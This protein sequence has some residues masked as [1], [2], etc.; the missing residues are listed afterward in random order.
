MLL[1]FD[2]RRL[3][4]FGSLGL[5]LLL[6]IAFYHAPDYVPAEVSRMKTSVSTWLKGTEPSLDDETYKDSPHFNVPTT[7]PADEEAH[8][9]HAVQPS[10]DYSETFSQNDKP[11]LQ[12]IGD[13]KVD[14][15]P[16][17]RASATRA[18]L[19][20]AATKQLP[21]VND[22]VAVLPPIDVIS[23]SADSVQATHSVTPTELPAQHTWS[24]P[25]APVTD[26]TYSL[27]EPTKRHTV[28]ET[29][30]A[31]HTRSTVSSPTEA[32]GQA[33]DEDKWAR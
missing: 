31:T 11:A 12:V 9:E 2:R 29:T 22:F 15:L 24:L 17:D 1:N 4:I 32:V 21:D 30:L 13:D 10:I 28:L 18:A 20:S 27:P 7:P 3:Y 14:V 26:H 8:V 25:V 33:F 5:F 23:N 19:P 16:P 6:F